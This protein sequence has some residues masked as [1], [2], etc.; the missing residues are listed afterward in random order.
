MEKCET[1]TSSPPTL[2]SGSQHSSS[3]PPIV[4]K[5]LQIAGQL[6]ARVQ[7]DDG[8]VYLP[9]GQVEVDGVV[10]TRPSM[11]WRKW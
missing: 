5:M 3:D 4:D 8:E 1:S 11:D 9:D 2:A 6:K 7:G 10:D